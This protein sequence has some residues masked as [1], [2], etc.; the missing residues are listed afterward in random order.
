MK[1]SVDNSASLAAAKKVAIKLHLTE[2]SID[3]ALIAGAQSQSALIEALKVMQLPYG[4]IQQPLTQLSES[5]GALLAAR[6]AITQAHKD[7]DEGV[8]G[9]AVER[10][11]SWATEFTKNE[12]R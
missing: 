8:K 9:I 3:N 6:Q 10:P 7:L 1:D 5:L 4:M 2:K 12:M 11:N